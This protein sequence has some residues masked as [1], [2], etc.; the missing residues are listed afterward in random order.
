MVAQALSPILASGV[1]SLPCAGMAYVASLRAPDVYEEFLDGAVHRWV[2]LVD[3][4]REDQWPHLEGAEGGTLILTAL[5]GLHVDLLATSDRA[6]V[7][8]ALETLL[9]LFERPA[10]T[11]GERGR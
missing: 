2:G 3:A 5:R 1:D 9:R 11:V 7:G 6:R 10:P 4:I 8:R